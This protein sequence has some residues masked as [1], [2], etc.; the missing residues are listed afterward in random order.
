VNDWTK[1]INIEA[2]QTK[3]AKL[4]TIA[5]IPPM[6]N[7]TSAGTP[8]ATQNAP[9]PLFPRDYVDLPC[10]PPSFHWLRGEHIHRLI[11]ELIEAPRRSFRP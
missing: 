8:L 10:F 6:E 2:A 3:N 5:E 7:K 9:R 11:D 4:P 1:P